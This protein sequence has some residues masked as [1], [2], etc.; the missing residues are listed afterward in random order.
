V[1][2]DGIYWSKNGATV[3]YRAGT[4]PPGY[5]LS[6]SGKNRALATDGTT[7]AWGAFTASGDI[8]MQGWRAGEPGPVPLGVGGD[9]VAVTGSLVWTSDG[10]VLD[11][12]TGAT[13]RLTRSTDPPVAAGRT[14]AVPLAHGAIAVVDVTTL[15]GLN[16]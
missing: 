14:A 8:E 16:C 1:I 10:A 15:P 12:R 6:P 3:S 13:V 11:T 9:A 5:A 7:Y 4:L 2:G